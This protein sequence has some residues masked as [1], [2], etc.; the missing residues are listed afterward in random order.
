MYANLGKQIALTDE[1][2]INWGFIND[3]VAEVTAGET[4]FPSLGRLLSLHVI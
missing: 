2:V 4:S 3:P 1:T